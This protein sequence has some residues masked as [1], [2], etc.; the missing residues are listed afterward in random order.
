LS[1]WAAFLA[2]KLEAETNSEFFV[3]LPESQKLR[4]AEFIWKAEKFSFLSFL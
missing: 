4:K 1:F 2:E 3:L